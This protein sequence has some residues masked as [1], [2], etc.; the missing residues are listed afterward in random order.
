M[1]MQFGPQNKYKLLSLSVYFPSYAGLVEEIM[2]CSTLNN[3]FMHCNYCFGHFAVLKCHVSE[4]E[5]MLAD[6]LF[7]FPFLKS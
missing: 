5:K 4:K 1:M 6:N 3:T 2:L 7:S